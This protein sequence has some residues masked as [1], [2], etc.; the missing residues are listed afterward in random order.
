MQNIPTTNDSNLT[1]V[2]LRGDSMLEG[3]AHP[4]S[5]LNPGLPRVQRTC[6]TNKPLLKVHCS[7]GKASTNVITPARLPKFDYSVPH[8]TPPSFHMWSFNSIA[9]VKRSIHCVCVFR[10]SVSAQSFICIKIIFVS[11][12]RLAYM[13]VKSPGGNKL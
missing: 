2:F 13:T 5:I 1:K 3:K 11:K 12:Q 7:H 6:T 9:S 4:S 10:T 8:I